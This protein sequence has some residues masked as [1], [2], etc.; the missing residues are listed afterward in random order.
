MKIT[1]RRNREKGWFRC[2]FSV[3]LFSILVVFFLL[4]DHLTDYE[5]SLKVQEK[6]EANSSSTIRDV[7][8]YYHSLLEVIDNSVTEMKENGQNVSEIA[9]FCSDMR[10]QARKIARLHNPSLRHRIISLVLQIRDSYVYGLRFLPISLSSDIKNLIENQPSF[11]QKTIQTLKQFRNCLIPVQNRTCPSYHFLTT[12]RNKSDIEI[13]N[14]CTKSSDVF[15][16][17]S[18]L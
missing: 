1:S 18:A 5:L 11:F 17:I 6:K 12:V 3:F 4:P 8:E 9:F 15:D 14:S 16:K 2:A 13:L 7:R 10:S